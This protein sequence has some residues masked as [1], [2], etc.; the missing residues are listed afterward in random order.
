[1]PSLILNTCGTSLLTNG[2]ISD[3]LRRLISMY[4]NH[5]Q[6]DIE[7]DVFL[8]LQK[9]VEQRR[10]LLLQANEEN[11]QKI[12]AEL[13][14][15]LSWQSKQIP[16]SQDI[17]YLLATD[18]YL[19]QYTAE[20]IALWLQH[21]GYQTQVISSD[22]LNTASLQG[23]R[24]SL[25]SLVKQLAELFDGY[26]ANGYDIYFNLTGGFKGLN[27]FLQA[28][29]TI[30]ADQTFYLF[31]GSQELLYI[32]KLPFT[33]DENIIHQHL[34]IFRR[35]S[36]DL[37]VQRSDWKKIPDSLLFQLDEQTAILSEWGELLWQS[38]YKHI[39]QQKILES[40][41]ERVIYADS[42]EASTKS[43]SPQ[44]LQIINERIADLAVYTENDCKHALKSLDP[45]PLQEKQY[46]DRNLWECDLDSH[47]RI[48]MQKQGYRFVLEK[49]TK[50]L[51]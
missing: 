4:S 10:Q 9:H 7:P 18:T 2:G 27:G 50:A 16:D 11:A 24:Q 31:E 22:G 42:F 36:N 43:L 51:H 32:P 21:R 13:N 8:N 28:L 3:D 12:S 25:S 44:I 19:G 20:S 37:L 41:S 35:L 23:F 46:K 30:Y 26:K 38:G 45:K 17:Y 47:H 1:M 34:Y 6:Q 15:L 48:F 49:V 5:K 39:Y 40:I 33:L 14:S 29:S